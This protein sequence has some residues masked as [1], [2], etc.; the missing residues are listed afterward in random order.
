MA[1]EKLH[2]Q[3]MLHQKQQHFKD[4]SDAIKDD[5]ETPDPGRQASI[6]TIRATRSKRRQGPSRDSNSNGLPR[7]ASDTNLASKDRPRSNGAPADQQLPSSS[8]GNAGLPT[9]LISRHTFSGAP[10]RPTAGAAAK[11]S[12]T[13]TAIGKRKRGE[14]VNQ[15]PADQQIFAVLKFYFFPNNDTNPARKLRIRK[16]QE[17]GAVW[18]KNYNDSVTHVVVDKAMDYGLLL[19]FLKL[20]SLP[21]NT[22]VVSENYPA[23]CISFRAIIDPKLPQFRVKG[24]EPK[25][26][27]VTATG[28][29]TSL[30]L[31]PAGRS[32]MAREPETQTSN[33]K[34]AAA[35]PV[36]NS[37]DAEDGLEMAAHPSKAKTEAVSK[38]VSTNEFET[39][40]EQ[41]RS[42]Q[43]MPL[44]DEEGDSRPTS[45][46]GLPADPTST[47]SSPGPKKK[48]KLSYQDRF[49]CMKP[50]GASNTDNPNAATIAILDQM[51][52]YYDR[53]GDDWR[54]R[55]YRKAI[56]TLCNHPTKVRTKAEALALPQIGERLATKI[57]EIAFTN[58]LRRLDNT[59]TDVNDQILQTFMGIYGVGFAQASKWVDA[60]YTT[61]DEL[62]AKAELTQNQKIGIEH[63]EDFNSRIPRAE[64]EALGSVV[65]ETLLKIDPSFEVIVGGS[66]RRGAATSGDVDCII[67][68]TKPDTSGAHIRQIV[69]DRLVP[70]L[71]RMDFL[72]AELAVT[73]RDDG[74]KWHGACHLPSTTTTPIPSTSAAKPWRRIDLLLVPPSELGAALTYFTGNDIFNR[75]LR[76]LASTKGM[77]LNQRGLYKDVIRGKGREKVTEGTLVEGRSE[78][79][80]FE[81]LGVPWREARERNC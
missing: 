45:S 78:R 69:L 56:G 25:V 50:S 77:R 74:S 18:E 49:Q 15:V 62:V 75:S 26:S 17:F 60:G 41:A 22:V 38:P 24:Y 16:A 58:R 39:A 4:F 40:V 6:D 70:T 1:N 11:E 37:S 10:N 48:G 73:S 68:H 52:H 28:S 3:D 8:A 65:R 43:N 5:D 33:K 57:E 55:A 2:T 46:S 42:L 61:I 54:T 67:T 53:I 64:V 21:P 27:K 19:K 66:Y 80:I 34:G 30:R 44:D 47:P 7:S 59:K 36:G 13:R 63:Y 79:R 20:E 51:S 23:D 9:S 81:V 29:D 31:K 72:T 35:S 14:E 76:L 32:V 12:T 71:L